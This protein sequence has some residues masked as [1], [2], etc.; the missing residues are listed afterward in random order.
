MI[1]N[2]K[3]S[4]RQLAVL[5]ILNIGCLVSFAWNT[6]IGVSGRAAGVAVSAGMI[7]LL[8]LTLWSLWLGNSLLGHTILEILEINAGKII[9][10][11]IEIVYIILSI[12]ASS[13]MLRSLSGLLQIFILP[14][15]PIL[16]LSLL[17]LV[18]P[19]LMARDG[20][21]GLGRMSEIIWLVVMVIYIP[22]IGFALIGQLNLELFT[23]IFDRGLKALAEGTYLSAAY[24]SIFILFLFVITAALPRPADHYRFM[25]KA[26]LVFTPLMATEVV[27]PAIGTFGAEQA[28]SLSEIGLSVAKSA[29][30]GRF[31]QGLDIFIVVAYILV[32]MMNIGMCMYC[33]WT[34]SIRIFNNWKP[35]L[36]LIV[37]TCLILFLS[38]SIHSFNESVLLSELLSI[39]GI[40]PFAF[41]VLLLATASLLLRG[42]KRAGVKK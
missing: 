10:K 40:F 4:G 20:I 39:Y 26:L 11:M 29:S 30:L 33:G 24:F 18:L 7:V 37:N 25:F 13:L 17:I 16:V 6:I 1:E 32:T 36:W 28:G 23:P 31:I 22:G 41:F 5:L 9:G 42:K 12:A 19:V 15:T 38:I 34:A 3:I 8:P 21:E 2:Q 35:N 27:L 14:D